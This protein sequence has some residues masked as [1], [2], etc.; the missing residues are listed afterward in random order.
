M[1]A[2]SGNIDL[3]DAYF[4][5]ADLDQDGRISGGE[6]VAFFQGSNLPKNVLAQIW[7]HANQKQTDFLG[8]PE[9]YNALRLVTVAQSGR[10]LTPDLVKAALFG[11]A[12]AKIPAPKITSVPTPSAQTNSTMPPSNTMVP[13]S[14]QMGA[15]GAS[16]FPNPSIR[17]Q[18]SLPS[19]AMNQ[20]LFSSPNNH[21][22]RPPQGPTTSASVPIQ[23]VGQVPA[24]GNMAGPRFPSS[25][26]PNL[27]TDW[28]LGRTSGASVGVTSQVPARGVTPVNQDTSGLAQLGT[29]S[30]SIM[31][32]EMPPTSSNQPRSLDLVMSSPQ[33]SA[34]ERSLIVS[35]NGFSSDSVFGDV[36]SAPSQPKQQTSVSTFSAGSTANS[37]N[38]SSGSQG[39]FKPGQPNYTQSMLALPPVGSQSQRTQSLVKQNQPDTVQSTSALVVSNASVGPA[40]SASN[41]SQLQ[42][43]SMTQSNI[44]KYT[45]VFVKVDKDRDGKITGEEA[46][47]LFLSWKLPREVLKQVWDLSDQDNDS[48]LSLREFCTALYLMERY[49]E[50]RPLPAV[51]PNNLRFDQMLAS[52][53]QPSTTYNSSVWQQNPGISQQVISGPRPAMP[54]SGMKPPRA[55]VPLPSEDTVQMQ[56]PKGRVPVLE[57][58]LVDQ[59][60]NEEQSALNSK[61]QEA[62]DADK[63][64]Q[65]LEKEILDSREKTEFYR[66]K[67]QELVLYKSRCDNR[68]NEITERVSADKREVKSL[69]KKYEDKYRQVG[70]VASRLTLDEA[71]FRDIQEKKMELY[72]AIAKMEQGGTSDGVLQ[73]RADRIQSDLEEV[74]KALNERC[75]QYGLRAKP[76]SLVELP[77]GWQPGLQE[78]AA[79]WDEDWDK[80]NDE[81]FAIIKELTI[82]VENVIAKPRP[83]SVRADKSST[84]EVSGVQSFSKDDTEDEKPS[85][86]GEHTGT[87]ITE[88]DPTHS[89]SPDGSG[90]SPPGSPTRNSL[91]SSSPKFQSNHSDIHSEVHDSSPHAKDSQS[92]YG[93]AESTISGD[94]YSDEPSW[95]KFDSNDDADS[96]WG[97]TLNTKE[98]DHDRSQHD[99][100]FGVRDFGLNPIRTESPS[101]ESVYGKERGPFFDSVPSTPLFQS[102]S[103]PRFSVSG[104]SPRFSEAP[105]D[106]SFDRFSRFDS[107]NMNDSGPFQTRDSFGRFDSMRS[108]ADTSFGNL[109]RFDSMRSTADAPFGSFERFD[110]M[111]STADPPVSSLARFDSMRSTTDAPVS[112]FARFDSMNNTTDYGHSFPSFDD[113]DP[114]GSTGPFKSSESQTPKR[115]TDHWSAF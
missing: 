57:K 82:E 86:V 46:R 42:W 4:R 12:A 97:S 8:R 55:P 98:T 54:P 14:T 44:Q 108:T 24:G 10:E 114:F 63:K 2:G 70:D 19:A 34:N 87:H 16:S 69:G 50:G 1:A 5:R 41:E 18:Q 109:S 56:P 90:K 32:P 77:F 84:D 95:G 93:G 65:E 62:T 53:G 68:L 85:S 39:P 43:P 115:G 25:N 11:P 36:F 30:G 67:M 3:F 37:S 45:A 33:P 88:D 103:S 15:L 9:F 89:H 48:M 110:S 51:L 35:G 83:P 100:F 27:S 94:K 13:S 21:M 20:Q 105:E 17:G 29:T 76:T 40:P 80:F 75:K 23:G 26:T 64:V 112:G 58:N 104:S 99:S 107:F 38:I 28:F 59:L 78:G 60:S 92:E 31:K 74:V 91:E 101:A 106:H 111:R 81:G 71:T 52:T 47:N 7:T 113:A 96:I 73:D 66:T 72:N 22:P 61:F 6:A 79:D 49:R 102:G